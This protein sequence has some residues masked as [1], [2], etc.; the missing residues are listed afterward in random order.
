MPEA[1]FPK[2]VAEV[3]TT[4]ADI[5]RHQR[6]TEIVE[7]LESAHAWFDNTEYDNWNGGTYTWALHLEV[8]VPIFV[9]VEPR[10][11]KI[12][13]EIGEKLAYFGRSYAND[14]LSQV[15]ISRIAAGAPVV[16]QRIAPSE[17]E[18]RRLWPEGRFR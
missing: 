14:H 18:V 1:N 15:T 5:F 2:P 7:M 6:Q 13:K 8:P 9:S 4:L 17:I 11:S 12:E 16:G 3:V 10:L